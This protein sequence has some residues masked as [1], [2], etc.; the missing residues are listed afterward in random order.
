MRQ[1]IDGLEVDESV[2]ESLRLI[3]PQNYTGI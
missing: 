1:F 3:T 2:K